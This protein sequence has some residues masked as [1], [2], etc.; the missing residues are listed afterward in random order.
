MKS[1][2]WFRAI[3]SPTIHFSALLLAG[4]CTN[5][6]AQSGDFT[7]NALLNSAAP[8][9]DMAEN[10]QPNILFIIADDLN[11]ALGSYEESKTRPHYATVSTPNLDKLATQGIRFENAFVQN[12][13]CNPS[14][15]SLLS[16][17]R[18]A[19]HGVH[20]TRQPPRET[21]GDELRL[22]PEHFND[23][24]F[25]TARVGKVGH[26]SYEHIADWDSSNFALSR[27]PGAIIHFPGYLPGQDSSEVRDITWAEGSE[28]GMNRQEVLRSV[29]GR[30]LGLPLS[31]RATDELARMTPDGTTSQRIIQL[32]AQNRDKPF[33][34]AAGFH[35][36]HQPWVAPAEFF[37]QHPLD[38]IQLPPQ[39]EG[40]TVDIPAPASDVSEFD[41]R[42]SQDQKK[43]AIAAYHATVTMTD[44][45]V[46]ELMQALE[47]L[48][49]AEST[50][51]VF[52]S[53][54]GF[55][56]NE[57]GGLW[58][59]SVQFDE[60]IRV[61]LI[62][63]LPDGRNAGTVAPGLVELVDLYPTLAELV[64][65][66]NPEH[67]FEGLS[68]VPVLENP[69]REWKSAAFSQSRRE[70]HDGLTI[71]TSRYRYTQ[72]SPIEGAGAT[73]Q[74]LYDLQQDPM[75]FNNLADEASH[76]GLLAELTERLAQ[77]WQGA[78]PQGF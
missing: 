12:P 16:G 25:Y 61:P 47:D 20:T 18:P 49:L 32:M 59:K 37:E 17:L 66:P 9:R 64:D 63:R 42:L 5:A 2:K 43:Q 71:R 8:A 45:Y 46:G 48:G 54:H 62:V 1:V 23:H 26:N 30:P 3:F 55:Q 57:H 31:W 44:T 76:A 58:R 27:E 69:T 21:L 72:W 78:L 51:V 53:D 29:G 13:L 11:L 38:Q 19:S 22:L 35:K 15:A 34:I 24:G 10:D 56:L 77:G 6:S 40:D 41:A 73:M 28:N 65:L 74:E 75:E 4:L 60:S 39:R 67:E 7:A 33:F 52:T 68:F 14:R 70:G 50:I 36:P